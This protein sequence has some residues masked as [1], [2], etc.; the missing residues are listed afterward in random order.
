[1]RFYIEAKQ[2]RANFIKSMGKNIFRVMENNNV[3]KT[4]QLLH[5]WWMHGYLSKLS[6]S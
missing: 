6:L 3:S 2:E 1:M 4:L 5:H